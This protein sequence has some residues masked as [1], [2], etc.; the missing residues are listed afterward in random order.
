MSKF[1]KRMLIYALCM[2]AFVIGGSLGYRNNTSMI[3]GSEVP[4]ATDGVYIYLN[5]IENPTQGFR[6]T[7]ALTV[8]LKGIGYFYPNSIS[9]SLCD[10]NGGQLASANGVKDTAGDYVATIPNNFNNIIQ[11]MSDCYLKINYAFYDPNQK[12]M[13]ETRTIR[14]FTVTGSYAGEEQEPIFN[15][16]NITSSSVLKPGMTITCNAQ[17]SHGTTVTGLQIQLIQNG[18]VIAKTS[19]SGQRMDYA[20]Q[21]TTAYDGYQATITVPSTL[22][23][24]PKVTVKLIASGAD[25]RGGG[26]PSAHTDEITCSTGGSSD[27]GVN[28][29]SN[30]RVLINGYETPKNPTPLYGNLVVNVNT[31]MTL[32]QVMVYVYDSNGRQIYSGAEYSDTICIQDLGMYVNGADVSDASMKVVVYD[33]YRN[34]YPITIPIHFYDDRQTGQTDKGTFTNT[35]SSKKLVT[36][37]VVSYKYKAGLNEKIISMR[38]RLL[39]EYNQVIA[40]NENSPSSG[41]T[42]LDVTAPVETNNVSTNAKLVCDVTVSTP[43]GTKTWTDTTT[44]YSVN[45]G[46]EIGTISILAGTENW[47][48]ILPGTLLQFNTSTNVNDKI[49]SFEVVVEKDGKTIDS[50]KMSVNA[51]AHSY[52]YKINNGDYGSYVF[53]ITCEG[54]SNGM[55]MEPASAIYH[56]EVG[57]SEWKITL[58][59]NLAENQQIEMSKLTSTTGVFLINC[60]YSYQGDGYLSKANWELYSKKE[61]FNVASGTA[62]SGQF[63][64]VQKQVGDINEFFRKN[65]SAVGDYILILTGINEKGEEVKKEFP[66]T[67]VDK[68]ASLFTFASN[69]ANGTKVKNGDKITIDFISSNSAAKKVSYSFSNGDPNKANAGSLQ[70]TVS[71]AKISFTVP[72]DIKEGSGLKALAINVTGYDKD[73]NQYKKT[74]EFP[75]ETEETPTVVDISKAKIPENK[76]TFRPKDK[77]DFDFGSSKAKVELVNRKGGT[78]VDKSTS[79][80]GSLSMSSLEGTYDLKVTLNDEKG[81]EV[82]E[83]YTYY[84]LDSDLIV[85]PNL[86][87]GL[88]LDLF[89]DSSE[90]FFSSKKTIPMKI[91]YMN[92]G[93]SELDDV[94]VKVNVPE[95]MKLINL[96]VGFTQTNGVI[97]LGKVPAGYFGVITFA[98]QATKETDAKFRIES[99]I[100]TGTKEKDTSV[101][102]VYFFKEGSETESKSYIT[103]YPDG[104]MKPDSEI[105]RSEVAAI[106]T[107]AFDLDEKGKSSSFKDL[108]KTSWAY[109]YVNA[110]AANDIITG[111]TDGTFKGSANITV[112]EL[113][114]MIYRVTKVDINDPLLVPDKYESKS[115]WE[116]NY[117]S[118]LERLNMLDSLQTK[119]W[120][121]KATR[122]DVIHLVNEALFINPDKSL[123][124]DFNDVSSSHVYKSDIAVS[125][126]DLKLTR[127]STGS[128]K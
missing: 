22:Q 3:L 40:H 94:S 68:N 86:E 17:N 51:C 62:Q 11:D 5:G 70:N 77:L 76:K 36:N 93:S 54:M 116:K 102:E 101:T 96:G 28:P 117:I 15:F 82:T 13:T 59:T 57:T 80:S 43:S 44:G 109:P 108:K 122:G 10:P 99:S 113:A 58:E 100:L 38:I 39:D 104:T 60:K 48:H 79:S 71:Q 67:V 92:S 114:T 33:R 103:G 105:T 111:Y 37:D 98:M 18:S 91:Y 23:V 73:D 110:C 19:G 106:F 2:M 34:Q 89:I 112:S 83:V 87:E 6:I 24:G 127:T 25:S 126:K 45:V 9:V 55:M 64:N 26:A 78:L 74:F 95:G 85:D 49:T 52:G 21:G 29:Y 53:Y 14:G 32:D 90:R 121:K 12:L 81:K 84:V 46:R 125:S 128:S 65:T 63:S 120:S 20:Y 16:G 115:T 35:T 7:D 123:S 66:F 61:K 8:K 30:I 47:A 107:R 69:P 41:V 42:T 75:L 119:D 31:S 118:G 72:V 27:P 50:K 4:Q 1:D 88:S 56:Y 124:P 97:K